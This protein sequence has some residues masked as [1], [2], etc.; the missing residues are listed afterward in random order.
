MLTENTTLLD[1][2]LALAAVFLGLSLLVQV[3]QEVYKHLTSSKARAYKNA[4][5]D[6]IGPWAEQLFRP[7]GMLELGLRGPLQFLQRRPS[8]RLLPMVAETL[9]GSL[10][11]MA[12]PWHVRALDAI[13][14]E[15][16]I[17]NGTPKHPSPAWKTF[18]ADLISA[19]TVMTGYRNAEEV[20]G[21]LQR[22]GHRV[23]K[24]KGG[25]PK[26]M[27][28]PDTLDAAGLE[29]DHTDGSGVVA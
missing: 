1:T 8:G 9:I 4:L 20:I 11:Q 7:G 17:Q 12:P 28:V 16:R 24:G 19:E 29:V 25:K 22:W 27:L 23:R 21:F 15:K 3:I 14:T 26:R 13:R 2:L 6:F 10:E 18:V 5:M